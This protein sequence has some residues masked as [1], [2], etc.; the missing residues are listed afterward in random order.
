MA[1][2]SRWVVSAISLGVLI[3]FTAAN[4]RAYA[5]DSTLTLCDEWQE[6]EPGT[7]LVVNHKFGLVGACYTK[8]IHSTPEAGYCYKKHETC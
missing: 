3:G 6:F 5:E 8:N 7:G 4:S 1:M 2:P